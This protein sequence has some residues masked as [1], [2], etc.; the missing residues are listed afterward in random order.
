VKRREFITL[1]GGRPLAARA[2]QPMPVIGFLGGASPTERAS[3][4]VAFQQGLAQSGYVKPGRHEFD[5][6]VDAV[7]ARDRSPR[8]I[9]MAT[10]RLENPAAYTNY[11]RWHA[12]GTAQQQETSRGGSTDDPMSKLGMPKSPPVYPESDNPIRPDPKSHRR[13]DRHH[14]QQV[15]AKSFEEAVSNEMARGCTTYEVAAQ[16][17]VNTYGTTLPH[18]SFAK[19]ATDIGVTFCKYADDFVDADSTMPRTEACAPRA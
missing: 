11:Q 12:S 2:Q 13:R 9:A 3:L 14:D 19:C 7:Q 10:A 17:V 18:E 1:L 4:L 8:Q 5:N 16:R 15:V 6:L